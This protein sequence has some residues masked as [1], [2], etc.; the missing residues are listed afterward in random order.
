[1]SIP[2]ICPSCENHIS[3][4]HAPGCCY[5]T[6]EYAHIG[7]PTTGISSP[8]S[9]SGIVLTNVTHPVTKTEAI[10]WT[11]PTMEELSKDGFVDSASA[12][13]RLLAYL[14]DEPDE[15]GPEEIVAHDISE[16]KADFLSRLATKS[17]ELRKEAA[18]M[19]NIE[20][21]AKRNFAADILDALIEELA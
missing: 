16:Y 19:Y 17:E 6:P 1:M 15:A 3:A 4:P 21:R 11:P 20:A 13:R 2:Q 12:I 18:G 14:Q 5:G 10:T 8:N 7:W 9:N